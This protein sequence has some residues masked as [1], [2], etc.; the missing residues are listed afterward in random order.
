[1]RIRHT[2]AAAAGAL[3]LV[4]T[5]PGSASAADGEFAYKYGSGSAGRMLDPETSNCTN[6]PEATEASP[7]YAPQN[8][9]NG[10]ATFFAAADC[11]G[12][13]YVQMDPGATL[14]DDVKGLSVHF[15]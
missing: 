8:A 12:D 2:M 3:L 9:T 6:I 11:E 15:R 4:L 10:I 14:G 5:L 7:A 13:A 1:M